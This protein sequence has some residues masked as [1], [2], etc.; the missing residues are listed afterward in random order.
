[1]PSDTPNLSSL[2]R[3]P[4]DSAVPIAKNPGKDLFSGERSEGEEPIRVY[5]VK[6]DPGDGPSKK[7]SVRI[8]LSVVFRH[9]FSLPESISA[10]RL[11]ILLM[12]FAY[13]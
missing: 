4:L 1:M 3:P 11:P 13:P 12:S 2:S 9:V 6:L 10:S 8:Y 7:R 5:E